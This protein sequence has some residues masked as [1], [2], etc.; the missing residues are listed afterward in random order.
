[1]MIVASM[2][3]KRCEQQGSVDKILALKQSR[4]NFVEAIKRL[5]HKPWTRMGWNQ[6][7][8]MSALLRNGV[9]SASS[10]KMIMVT[11]TCYVI[12][13]FLH[14]STLCKYVLLNLSN[15]IWLVDVNFIEFEN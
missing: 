4:C 3:G 1:M 10:S 8:F 12:V 9:E 7:V 5:T 11:C 13:S 15:P 2:N 14:D 6:D